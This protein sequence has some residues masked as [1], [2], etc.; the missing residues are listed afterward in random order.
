MKVNWVW[1]RYFILVSA[2]IHEFSILKVLANPFRSLHYVFIAFCTALETLLLLIYELFIHCLK[3]KRIDWEL[4]EI[5]CGFPPHAVYSCFKVAARALMRFNVEKDFFFF[6]V[7]SE[8]QCK[9]TLITLIA[10]L[11]NWAS[12]PI[13]YARVL[14]VNY[15]ETGH[16]KPLNKP[17]SLVFP[18]P[19]LI[20]ITN[21]AWATCLT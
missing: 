12:L 11:I 18:V 10:M 19:F 3:M 1:V 16:M 20:G 2:F 5:F 4:A 9:P 6:T 8:M 15:C 7:P 17:T 13:C 14:L 21:W